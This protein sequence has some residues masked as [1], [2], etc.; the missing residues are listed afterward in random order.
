M[1]TSFLPHPGYCRYLSDAEW[2]L[3]EC[4]AGSVVRHGDRGGAALDMQMNG[5]QFARG[6]TVRGDSRIDYRLKGDWQT[7][8]V[9]AGRDDRNDNTTDIRFQ[10]YGDH[11]L[12]YDSGPVAGSAIAKLEVDVRGITTLSLRTVDASGKITANW[13]N[14][15]LSGFSGDEAGR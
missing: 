11:R 13:A 14:A 10:V 15:V 2:S 12:L 9:E 5:L 6:L 3:A 7:F 1:N 8:R 4:A